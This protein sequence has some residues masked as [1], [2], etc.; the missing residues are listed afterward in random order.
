MLVVGSRGWRRFDGRDGLVMSVI[1]ALFDLQRTSSLEEA[2]WNEL[3][4]LELQ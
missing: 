3:W 2:S 1:N 4:E